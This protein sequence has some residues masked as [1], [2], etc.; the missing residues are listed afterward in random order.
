MEF[1]EHRNSEDAAIGSKT[2]KATV[3]SVCRLVPNLTS[4]GGVQR[5]SNGTVECRLH[6]VQFYRQFERIV[7]ADVACESSGEHRAKDVNV[8]D[9]Y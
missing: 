4:H 3:P 7:F 1:V 9:A 2:N 8:C 5:V 6:L